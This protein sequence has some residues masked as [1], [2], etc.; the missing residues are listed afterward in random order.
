MQT[1]CY[2]FLKQRNKLNNFNVFPIFLLTNC[3][4]LAISAPVY[5]ASYCRVLL[6]QDTSA[7]LE[8]RFSLSFSLD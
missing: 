2:M 1:L 4:K 5:M 6:L 7:T 3:T 8:A